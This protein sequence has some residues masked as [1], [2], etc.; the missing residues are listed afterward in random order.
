MYFYIVE[1][2]Y[3]IVPAD[4]LAAYICTLSRN[5]IFTA[6]YDPDFSQIICIIA[7]KS[8]RIFAVYRRNKSDIITLFYLCCKCGRFAVDRDYRRCECSAFDYLR[9]AVKS[10][11]KPCSAVSHYLRSSET[12]RAEQFKHA[13]R[14]CIE[15]S[16][17]FAVERHS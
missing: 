12:C 10:E 9:F 13:Q 15:Y 16:Y 14:L 8:V 4:F 17:L 2:L 6:E 7:D 5:R 1:R 11:L 3:L